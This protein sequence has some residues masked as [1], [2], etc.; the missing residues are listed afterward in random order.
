MKS[1]DEALK[2]LQC[3]KRPSVE[4]F[5]RMSYLLHISKGDGLRLVAGVVPAV[6]SVP[7][8]SGDPGGRLSQS[9]E[10]S[11]LFSQAQRAQVRLLLTWA[12]LLSLRHWCW[13]GGL[14][15]WVV[16]HL[17]RG[18]GLLRGCLQAEEEARFR[19]KNISTGT[20]DKLARS[21]LQS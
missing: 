3:R 20:S 17:L 4:Q 11:H 13:F 15:H 21:M 18:D 2:L 14:N 12:W 1:H 6:S 10:Q 16:Q 19:R 9:V 5:K 7:S 8:G